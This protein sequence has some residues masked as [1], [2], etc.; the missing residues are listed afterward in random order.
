MMPPICSAIGIWIRFL[1]S[2]AWWYLAPS[3][4]A[5]L[6]RTPWSI[7]SNTPICGSLTPISPLIPAPMLHVRETTLY[8]LPYFVT[9]IYMCVCFRCYI[10]GEVEK[11]Y[12]FGLLNHYPRDESSRWSR[13][14]LLY[15]P[16]DW[17][18]AQGTHFSFITFAE[19]L[20]VSFF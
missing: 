20:N 1:T 19:F 10:E 2:G 17:W 3:I 11:D 6:T 15:F 4:P 8:I 13:C 9:N 12:G 18:H 5:Y 14:Y 16:S 7:A